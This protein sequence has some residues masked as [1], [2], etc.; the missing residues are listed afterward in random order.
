MMQFQ[1]ADVWH[2]APLLNGHDFNPAAMVEVVNALH[3][4]GEAAASRIVRTRAESL[5]H[6][7]DDGG[8]GLL[9][10]GQLSLLVRLLWCP[11]PP[12]PAWPE[13]HLGRPDIPLPPPDA[14]WPL[15]PLVLSEDLPFLLVGGYKLGGSLLPAT[16]VLEQLR[17][18]AQW[19]PR[20]LMP[21]SPPRL[22]LEKLVAS[23]AWQTRIPQARQATLRAMLQLQAERAESGAARIG[24]LA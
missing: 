20:P 16:T 14:T 21:A 6:A 15:L 5:D 11:A 23:P 10:R 24:I 19:R 1:N 3:A 18:I 22:A 8:Q 2:K 13:L 4:M 7:R 12:H 9:V 17:A